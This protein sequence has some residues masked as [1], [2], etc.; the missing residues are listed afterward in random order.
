MWLFYLFVYEITLILTFTT[1]HLSRISSYSF[2]PFLSINILNLNDLYRWN[3]LP[4]CKYRFL[5]G[6]V[7][8]EIGMEL[9]YY[10]MSGVF[11]FVTL[12][13]CLSSTIRYRMYFSCT[14]FAASICN[15]V[16]KIFFVLIFCLVPFLKEKLQY[17]IPW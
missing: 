15:F 4:V 6:L 11:E 9:L 16:V 2:Q 12:I 5:V 17:W 14:F 3:Y 7:Y 1:W 10:I 13:S 8:I